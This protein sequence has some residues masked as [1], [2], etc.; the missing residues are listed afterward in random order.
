M[1]ASGKRG[2]GQGLDTLLQ[3]TPHVAE[4]PVIFLSAY[5]RDQ[6]IARALGAGADY[7]V[8]P[9]SPAELVARIQAVPRQRAPEKA[10][11]IEALRA[12]GRD[13]ELR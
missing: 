12:G 4:V 5:D 11:A 9:F 2:T 7:I 8:K 1:G 3:D 13:G 10:G 6:V